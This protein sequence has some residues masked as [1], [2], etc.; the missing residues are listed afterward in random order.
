MFVCKWNKIM[1]EFKCDIETTRVQHVTAN[2][3]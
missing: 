1:K 2:R 3:N